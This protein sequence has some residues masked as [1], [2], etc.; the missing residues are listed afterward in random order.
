MSFQSIANLMADM[1]QAVMKINGL[2]QLISNDQ[3]TLQT[4]MQ[5]VDMS[6]SS[7]RM[8]YIDAEN[9]EFERTA[10]PMTGVADTVQMQ[11]LRVSAAA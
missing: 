11:M 10:T 3:K 2:A 7:G 8:L 1:S 5:M 9:E 6:R 4:R